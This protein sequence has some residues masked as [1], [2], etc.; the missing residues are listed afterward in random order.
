[1]GTVV[2]LVRPRRAATCEG[3]G[4]SF[5]TRDPIPWLCDSCM[6]Q[7]WDAL[8]EQWNA[9]ARALGYGSWEAR[10]EVEM[11]SDAA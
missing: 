3:C 2:Q 1:M 7:W 5:L 9:E 11:G 6:A 10:M 4:C 8:E